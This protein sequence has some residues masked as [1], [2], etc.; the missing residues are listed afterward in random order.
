M[1]PSWQRSIKAAHNAG[2]TRQTPRI[3]KY[4]QTLAPIRNRESFLDRHGAQQSCYRSF[5]HCEKG[6]VMP[7][8]SKNSYPPRLA[9]FLLENHFITT[10]QWLSA[11]ATHW[12]QRTH[13]QIG[14]T[15]VDEGC[16]PR[17][18]LELQARVFHASD[19]PQSDGGEA[20]APIPT[21]AESMLV[22]PL[23]QLDEPYEAIEINGDIAEGSR[24]YRMH[25]TSAIHPRLLP[26]KW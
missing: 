23:L 6:D 11:L 13:R 17:A 16:L 18:V 12:S 20:F 15:L 5:D 19:E 25:S 26:A 4:L 7:T 8:R 3:V 22:E 21:A 14:R 10:E 2:P 1:A 9:E 24:P